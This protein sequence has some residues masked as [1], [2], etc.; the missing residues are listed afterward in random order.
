MNPQDQQPK[1]EP[2]KD[3]SAVGAPVAEP[4]KSLQFTEVPTDTNDPVLRTAQ[5]EQNV[6]EEKNDVRPGGEQQSVEAKPTKSAKPSGP[7]APIFTVTIAILFFAALAIVAYFA[8][9]KSL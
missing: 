2:A 5:T 3:A 8:Y 1:A 9:T 4:P 6:K 7:K